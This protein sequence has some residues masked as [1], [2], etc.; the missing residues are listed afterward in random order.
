VLTRR[1]RTGAALAVAGLAA[2]VALTVVTHLYPVSMVGL[3]G[4]RISNMNPPTVALAA[5][6]TWLIGLVLLLRGPVT[7]WLAGRRVWTV[8]VGANGVVMTTFLWHLTALFAVYAAVLAS[9]LPLPRVGSAAWWLSRPVWIAVLALVCAALVSMFRW[10]ERPRRVTITGGGAAAA[11]VG[12][13]AACL[14]ILGVALTG[15]DGLLAGHSTTLVIIPMTATAG[16]TLLTA[17]WALVGGRCGQA[18]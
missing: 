3:P 15:L 11:V 6:A 18:R 8:V 10:A 13:T 2:V 16:I 1:K 4:E 14:G 17:G 5:H 7:R 12:S 9:P